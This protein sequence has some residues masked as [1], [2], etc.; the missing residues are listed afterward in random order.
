VISFNYFNVH[1]NTT[2]SIPSLEVY[3]QRRAHRHAAHPNAPASPPY[4]QTIQLRTSPVALGLWF[5]PCAA[6]LLALLTFLLYWP[7]GHFDFVQFD[8]NDYVFDNTT[9]RNGL[10][11]WGLVWSFVDAHALNWHPVTWL[12]HMLDCQLF[13]LNPGAHHFI[14]LVLHSINCALL[15]IL[16]NRMTRAVWRSAFVAALF[17]WH[18]LRVESVA[19]VSERKDVLSGLFFMLTLLAYIR[20][21]KTAGREQEP[22]ARSK[23]PGIV[24]AETTRA[25]RFKVPGLKFQ[26]PGSKSCIGN[27]R[28]KTLASHFRSSRAFWYSSSLVCFVFGLLSKPMLITVPFILLLIDFWPL[29]RFQPRANSC[30]TF[31]GNLCNASRG[32]LR[33]KLPFFIC[34]AVVGIITL[35]SQKS[36]GAIVSLASE[37]IFS[38]LATALAGYFVYLEKFFWP[39][40]LSVLYLRPDATLVPITI[41]GALVLVS[42]SGL[43]L[44]PLLSALGNPKLVIGASP[45]VA[46]SPQAEFSNRKWALPIGWL[47]FVIM[48]LPV[49]GL[50]QVGPQFIADRYTY[51]PSIGLA[52]ILAWLL[53]D[54]M[55]QRKAQN[56][57]PG[58][59]PPSHVSRFTFYALTTLVLLMC[60][61]AT[62]RQLRYWQ[63]TETLMTHAL[64]LDPNN[65]IAHQDLAVYYAKLG[66]TDLARAHR[67]RVRELDPELKTQAPRPAE[68]V[69]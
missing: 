60:V 28:W 39:R 20:Y 29:N 69:R 5:I 45:S 49:C 40:D 47:W 26:V 54:L 3:T 44:Y 32:L 53:P 52:I 14:N 67:Q 7:A 46:N 68:T 35:L 65:Y 6:A 11:W 18:P 37:G 23:D 48:L 31:F 22:D 25:P 43:A 64:A 12:S 62:R 24:S 36:G 38:R 16:L 13:G 2:K 50:V 1:L 21:A 57:K 42:L 10:T 55:Q 4:Q 61:A 51:L 63:N 33:E 27:S 30:N 19:W 58:I 66:K 17:A 34:S 9:V 56:T 59:R 8:D 41:G 15:F